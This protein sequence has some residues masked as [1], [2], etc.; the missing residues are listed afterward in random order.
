VKE[1]GVFQRAVIERV[2]Y[3]IQENDTEGIII[4]SNPAHHKIHGC[5][6]GELIGKSILDFCS[7]DTA[8]KELADYLKYLVKAQPEP[9][10]FYDKN[11]TKD[12]R[13][14]DVSVDWNYK[15]DDDGKVVGFISAI[16]DITERKRL[17]ESIK[18]SEIKY[19]DLF[20]NAND[21]IFI[22]DKNLNY[23]DAN[24]K[25]EELFGYTKEEI[26]QINIADVIPS[27]Q[28]DR[29]DNTFRKLH[30]DGEY[31]KFIGKIKTKDGRW[32]DIEVNSSAII[33]NGQ[34]IG[35][36][37]IVRDI[38]HRLQL[39]T[40]LRQSQK[41]EAIGTLAGGI[42]HD[43]NNILTAVLGYTELVKIDLPP[44]NPTTANLDEVIKAAIRAKELVQH[45]LTFSR[46][47]DQERGPIQIHII[48]KEALKLLRAS[49][50]TT[51][52]IKQ[53]IDPNS[54][55]ILGN[56]TQIHQVLM[57]LCT[58]A[59]HAMEETGGTIAV[60]LTDVE[61]ES[62]LFT[63]ETVLPPGH[64]V[65]LSISD[66][67]PGIE[68]DLHERIFEPYFTT[69]EVGKGSGLGLAVVH[70]I[71]KAH[72]GAIEFESAPGHGTSFHLYFPMIDS[73]ITTSSK[74]NEPLPTGNEK[75]LIVDDEKTVV[76]LEKRILGHL[77]YEVIAASSSKEAL[78]IF[79]NAPS[80][81]AL[82]I[83]D[84]TMPLMTGAE[85]SK[86]LLKI[87]PDIPIILC[88]GYS[89]L[90]DEKK[91]TAIGIKAFAMKPLKTDE[92]AKIVRDVLDNTIE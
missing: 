9:T 54:G 65:K 16:T 59:S 56:P 38:T 5:Q 46:K 32:L 63:A 7:S 25:A 36:R 69:K 85:L 37:D 21:A 51:I 74:K 89:S 70:G 28:S 78:E 22:I 13:I 44:N 40:Q 48:I 55:T 26:L 3:G 27:G 52:A 47:T 2:P 8:R 53:H 79:Q 33:E 4:F 30:T 29:S 45:I 61:L 60:E 68:A 31:E 81:F 82:V 67:G 84:H 92:L 77:G 57:N 71:I 20:E 39:E 14:I 62:E 24:K 19:R 43:F 72:V 1:R 50:P 35:S 90:M 12:N 42:A 18:T 73:E 15:R 11:R 83:T 64:Y 23:I 6:P 41:M 58:N 86:K 66:T 80:S 17:E 91:A 34:V 75:I 88:T 49:I 10:T 87:R 76:N